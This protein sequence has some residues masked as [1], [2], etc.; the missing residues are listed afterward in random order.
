MLTYYAVRLRKRGTLWQINV[1]S[2]VLIVHFTALENA[3]EW[4]SSMVY[5]RKNMHFIKRSHQ[6]RNKQCFGDL[7]AV[8]HLPDK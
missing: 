2:T 8:R 6:L 7:V 5:C 1:S 4:F 3:E